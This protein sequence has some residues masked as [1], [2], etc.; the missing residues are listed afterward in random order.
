M[1]INAL[2][3]GMSVVRPMDLEFGPDGAMYLIEW[4][5]GFGGNN[6]NSGVYRID[7]TNPD[8]DLAPIAVAAG[9]PTSGAAPLTVQFSSAGSRDPAGQPITYAWTFGDG[10]TSTAAN[11]SA[12]LHR[13]GHVQRPAHRPRPGRAY[14]RRQ[15]AHRRRQHHTHRAHHAA[16]RTAAS[17]SGATRSPTRSP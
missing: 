1:D 5:S 6:D 2:L 17:T 16:R 14:G 7:Y 12:H 13:H 10:G 9:Q 3:T 15:R 11:P 8:V 4:G